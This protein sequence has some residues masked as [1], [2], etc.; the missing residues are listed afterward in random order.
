MAAEP[1][2]LDTSYPNKPHGFEL[3]LSL[4][5]C[6]CIYADNILQKHHLLLLDYFAVLLYYSKNTDH[7]PKD[8]RKCRS[9]SKFTVRCCRH[10]SWI[11]H[12]G[13]TRVFP[14][15]LTVIYL[16]NTFNP[17]L[18]MAYWFFFWISI[19]L[20][21]IQDSPTKEAF[22]N[23]LWVEGCDHKDVSL[24]WYKTA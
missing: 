6:Y 17:L 13:D 23:P 10:L 9:Q 12:P 8:K 24:L 14:E 15:D 2:H 20:L 1:W 5:L 22:L 21:F 3:S 18:I 19:S 7:D 16:I 11:S 4:S